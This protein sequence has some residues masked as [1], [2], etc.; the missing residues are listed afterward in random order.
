MGSSTMAF[1]HPS[2]LSGFKFGEGLYHYHHQRKET[3]WAGSERIF[4]LDSLERSANIRSFL[5]DFKL[6]LDPVYFRVTIL[7]HV[8]PYLYQQSFEDLCLEIVDDPDVL[9][10]R[11]F[12]GVCRYYLYFDILYIMV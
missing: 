6:S 10:F 8:G 12:V 4:S 11:Q 5:F 9:H 1:A 7:C 2:S 3:V